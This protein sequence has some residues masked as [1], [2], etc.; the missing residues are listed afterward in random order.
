VPPRLKDDIER[1]DRWATTYD[2]SVWQRRYF[3]PIHSAVLDLIDGM[4]AVAP[5]GSVLDIGCGTGRLLRTAALRWPGARLFGVDPAERMI[6]EAARLGP[7]VAF[8]VAGAEGLPFPDRSMD[9]V[10][11]SLS[12]HHWADQ[13]QGLREIQ[14]V[15]RPGG[16]FALA[17]HMFWPGG[18][19]N[20]RIHRHRALDALFA[21][22][23]LTVV[24]HRTM[25][26]R[27]V[28]LTMAVS[29]RSA[30]PASAQQEISRAPV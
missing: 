29:P 17:D 9:L 8:Q 12:F 16:A 27:F 14:R 6:S 22:A 25:R 13:S 26:S 7:D 28:L 10:V 21:G 2:Q 15:L 18:L 11:S 19:F 3:L 23:G 30:K 24:A 4:Q 1:F 20:E 5:Q